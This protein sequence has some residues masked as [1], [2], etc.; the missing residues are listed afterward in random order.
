MKRKDDEL[1]AWAT[2]AIRALVVRALR[3]AASEYALLARVE[4]RR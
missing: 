4:A 3:T 1:H 2:A